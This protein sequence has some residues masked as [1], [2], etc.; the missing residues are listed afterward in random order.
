MKGEGKWIEVSADYEDEKREERDRDKLGDKL[1][2]FLRRKEEEDEANVPHGRNEEIVEGAQ[3]KSFEVEQSLCSALR[4]YVDRS[5]SC[6]DTDDKTL[7]IDAKP[8]EDIQSTARK[9]GWSEEEK[10]ARL[11]KQLEGYNP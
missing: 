5:G 4:D 6:E 2:A 8:L 7:A 11:W 3:H 9:V 10:T 1:D